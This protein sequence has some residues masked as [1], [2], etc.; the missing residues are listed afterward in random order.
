MVIKIKQL[1]G[2]RTFFLQ[3]TL[4]SNP[5]SLIKKIQTSWRIFMILLSKFNVTFFYIILKMEKNNYA[6]KTKARKDIRYLFWKKKKLSRH[7]T[8]IHVFPFTFYIESPSQFQYFGQFLVITG[9][10]HLSPRGKVLGGGGVP[11]HIFLFYD[12]Q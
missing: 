8:Y 7:E 1:F 2:K 10:G 4:F 5:I 6:D 12:L 11:C 3:K 9:L